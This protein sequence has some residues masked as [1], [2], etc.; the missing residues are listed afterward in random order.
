MTL[1]AYRRKRNFRNTPEPRAR[2]HEL[3]SQWEQAQGNVFARA[4]EKP[5]AM[6]ADQEACEKVT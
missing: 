2:T 1:T 4:L 5:E 6:A 3:R